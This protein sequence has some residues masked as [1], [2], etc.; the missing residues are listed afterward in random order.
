MHMLVTLWRDLGHILREIIDMDVEFDFD[1]MTI[2][3]RGD[4]QMLFD[5]WYCV[6]CP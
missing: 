6:S 3:M 5:S 2:R 4:A 1:K